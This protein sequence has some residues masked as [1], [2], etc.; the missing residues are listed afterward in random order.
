M[1]DCHSSN[2]LVGT[3]PTK[4][5]RMPTPGSRSRDYVDVSIDACISSVLQAL[6]DAEW[7]TLNCC[8]SHNGLTGENPSIVFPGEL[9]AKDAEAI[10]KVIATVDDRK[11]DLHYWHSIFKTI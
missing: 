2:K 1:C 8:C 3:T 11:F 9:S 5:M 6:W 10:R 7:Y 4:I